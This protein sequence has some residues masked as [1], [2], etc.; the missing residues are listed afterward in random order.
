MEKQQV[1]ARDGLNRDTWRRLAGI[2][3]GCKGRFHQ[4]L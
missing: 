3:I 2:Q 1:A 4:C